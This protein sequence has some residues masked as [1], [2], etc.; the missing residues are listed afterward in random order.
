MGKP[1]PRRRR[2]PWQIALERQELTSPPGATSALDT[3]CVES[4]AEEAAAGMHA[5]SSAAE[6]TSSE[7]VGGS[8][9]GAAPRVSRR[10]QPWLQMAPRGDNAGQ[11]PGQERSMPERLAKEEE[12]MADLER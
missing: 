8:S 9:D 7:R 10:S 6:A 1:V 4:G 11:S 12:P 3:R 2:Q 5:S